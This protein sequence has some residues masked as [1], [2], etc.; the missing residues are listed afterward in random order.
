MFPERFWWW[1]DYLGGYL[2][3]SL[4]VQNGLGT[5]AVSGH[6]SGPLRE[7]SERTNWYPPS[8]SDDHHRLAEVQLLNLLETRWI[9]PELQGLDSERIGW[10]SYH[11]VTGTFG[12]WPE[13]H[14]AQRLKYYIDKETYLVPPNPNGDSVVKNLD[15]IGRRVRLRGLSA[16][17][18]H[19]D[20]PQNIPQIGKRRH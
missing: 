3:L 5:W 9:K 18:R 2:G 4:F 17:G 6:L 15:A 8:E 14:Y 20:V 11:V 16:R 13:G 1:H 19:H 12:D 7:Y 10:R